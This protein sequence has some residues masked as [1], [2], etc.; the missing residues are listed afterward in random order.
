MGAP[1]IEPAVRATE[2]AVNLLPEDDIN[3]PAYEITV[4]Y[5]GAGRWAVQRGEHACLGA[6]G[7]WADGV[8]P[9][10]RTDAWLGSHRFDLDT[11]LRLAR[12]AAPHVT[13]NGRTAVEA[14]AM[15]IK[16]S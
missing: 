14:L 11:A 2:Y 4:R 13:V 1:R 12:A 7:R 8:K 16:E 3:A 9:Y 15:N 10:G 6:D 5:R